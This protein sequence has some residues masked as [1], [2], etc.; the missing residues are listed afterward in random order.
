MGDCEFLS[1]EVGNNSKGQVLPCLGWF[2]NSQPSPVWQERA[3]CRASLSGD[4]GFPGCSKGCTRC[5]V[6]DTGR[7]W[8]CREWCLASLLHWLLTAPTTVPRGRPGPAP[9]LQT[10]P[11]AVGESVGGRRR[12]LLRTLEKGES[13]ILHFCPRPGGWEGAGNSHPAG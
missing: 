7:A 12:G 9:W 2:S 8:I 10:R 4:F 1:V 13:L 3:T 11:T 5:P 6:L